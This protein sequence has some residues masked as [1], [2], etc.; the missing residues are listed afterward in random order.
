MWSKGVTCATLGFRLRAL[1]EIWHWEQSAAQQ[2][3][4]EFSIQD[5]THWRQRSKQTD[6]DP[7]LHNQA[8]RVREGTASG[9]DLRNRGG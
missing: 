2:S 3:A 5:R 4:V 9:A 7:G 8:A 6:E 1:R